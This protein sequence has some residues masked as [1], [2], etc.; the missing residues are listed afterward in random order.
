MN[1]RGKVFILFLN[2]IIY[3]YL[4]FVFNSNLKFCPFWTLPNT[5]NLFDHICI[6]IVFKKCTEYVEKTKDYYIW[7][8]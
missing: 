8:C 1:Q 3:P 4:V 6:S 5:G 2:L 7:G